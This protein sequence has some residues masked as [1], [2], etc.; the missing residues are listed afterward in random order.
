[1]TV[2]KFALCLKSECVSYSKEWVEDSRADIIIYC[3]PESGHFSTSPY[4]S[5]RYSACMMC[6]HRYKFDN[7]RLKSEE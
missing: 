6:T 5:A 4:T 7:L 2:K 1:M 3:T